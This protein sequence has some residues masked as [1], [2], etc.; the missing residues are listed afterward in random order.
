[1]RKNNSA[2]S[3]IKEA[4]AIIELRYKKGSHTVGAA[5]RTGSGKIYTGISINGLKLH[6]CAE[7]TALGRAFI[8][9][10]IDIESIVAL[11]RKSDGSFEFFPPCALCREL[12]IKYC[13]NANVIL[14]KSKTVKAAKLLPLAWKN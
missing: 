7:W 12:L 5:L 2:D 6:L 13:P 9:G 11:H 4:K 3:L 10:E 14:S 8:D 1:M